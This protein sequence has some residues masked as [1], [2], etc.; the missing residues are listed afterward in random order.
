MPPPDSKLTMLQ[1]WKM[2]SYQM[3]HILGQEHILV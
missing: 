3:E 1:L 2:V